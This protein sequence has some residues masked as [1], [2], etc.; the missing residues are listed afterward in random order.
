LRLVLAFICV[1]IGTDH[2]ISPWWAIPLG[3]AIWIITLAYKVW[4][5]AV[6]GEE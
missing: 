4:M 1:I 5:T 2:H 3:Y 6:R